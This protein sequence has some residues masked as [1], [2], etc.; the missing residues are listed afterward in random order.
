MAELI[1]VEVAY[2]LP[3]EQKIIPLQV[4]K[5]ITVIEAI[6][7]SG[8]LA[9]YPDID[10]NESKIGIFGKLTTAKTELYPGD[11]VEIYR[12]LI[13]DPKAA[14]KKRAA[15]GKTMKKGESKPAS[16]S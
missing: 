16:K 13:A 6:E 9:L 5:G 4:I 1:T 2:A 3:E 15:E 8:I 10:I 11:R 12:K 7:Q 14:R